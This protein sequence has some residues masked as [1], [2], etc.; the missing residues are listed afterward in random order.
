MR[1]SSVLCSWVSYLKFGSL[2]PLLH[3][4][5]RWLTKF[6]NRRELLLQLLLM[7]LLQW[8]IRIVNRV[9][10]AVYVVFYLGD[11]LICT[12]HSSLLM[13]HGLSLRAIQHLLL[14]SPSDSCTEMFCW[15]VPSH[16]WCI[17]TDS[18][19]IVGS[20]E[21]LLLSLVQL[22]RLNWQSL[23]LELFLWRVIACLSVWELINIVFVHIVNGFDTRKL[24]LLRAYVEPSIHLLCLLYLE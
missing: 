13:G 16:S 4:H 21:E 17:S 8:P 10:D 1:K 15:Q 22:I 11:D 3:H 7:L 9:W 6:L 14:T 24:I 12:L 2:L 23:L 18:C 5:V 20:M 19:I